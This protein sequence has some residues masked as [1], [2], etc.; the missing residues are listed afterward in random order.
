M[1]NWY[2]NIKTAWNVWY[3]LTD[4]PDAPG[5]NAV[6]RNNPYGYIDR[7]KR[8]VHDGRGFSYT[9][10]GEGSGLGTRF[11]DED[12]LPEFSD[13][14]NMESYQEEAKRETIPTNRNMLM[15]R[16]LP[17]GTGPGVDNFADPVD[18]ATLVNKMNKLR[19]EPLGIQNMTSIPKKSL[20]RKRNNIFNYIADLA[21]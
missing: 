2:R 7:R 5:Y 18:Q 11:R 20:F 1:T 14:E 16:P 17:F 4:N 19:N 6:A 12:N 21:D 13:G 3:D 9:H 10:P 8:N 15:D